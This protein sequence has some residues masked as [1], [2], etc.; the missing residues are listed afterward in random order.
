MCNLKVNHIPGSSVI[1]F[2][3]TNDNFILKKEEAALRMT[4]VR[5]GYPPNS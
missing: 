4:L 3:L 1:A 5:N 2:T